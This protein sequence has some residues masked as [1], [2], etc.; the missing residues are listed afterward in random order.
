MQYKYSL[1]D[2]NKW[3]D[4]VAKIGAVMVGFILVVFG[5]EKVLELESNTFFYQNRL[6]GFFNYANSFALFL[7]IG[8]I[9]TGFKNKLKV[10]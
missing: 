8:I 7:L 3:F 9:I 5:V 1:E 2:K 10:M 6:A 4:F